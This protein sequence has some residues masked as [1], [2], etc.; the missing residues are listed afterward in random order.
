[1]CPGLEEWWLYKG[2]KISKIHDLNI[3]AQTVSIE[4]LVDTI[5]CVW[6]LAR[7]SI[8]IHANILVLVSEFIVV[9]IF[10]E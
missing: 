6:W 2:F 9:A 10:S 8:F 4:F 3:Y 5:F 7:L 1:M